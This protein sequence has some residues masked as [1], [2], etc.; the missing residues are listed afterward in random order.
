MILVYSCNNICMYS[1]NNTCKL[2]YLINQNPSCRLVTLTNIQDAVIHNAAM[3]PPPPEP[4][5]IFFARRVRWLLQHRLH[6]VEG[7][8]AHCLWAPE[9][10]GEG[11]PHRVHEDA[12][13]AACVKKGRDSCWDGGQDLWWL[14]EWLG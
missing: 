12:E 9:V 1:M 4:K 10:V 14:Y 5:R 13:G 7:Q 3:L 8:E 2:V 6:L 11:L